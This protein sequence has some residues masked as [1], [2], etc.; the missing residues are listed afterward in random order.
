MNRLITIL[1]LAS[2]LGV[3][4]ASAQSEAGT[5]K[6]NPAKSKY[7]GIATPMRGDT[8]GTHRLAS[9]ALGSFG[10]FEYRA[11]A[12]LFRL[13][14]QFEFRVHGLNRVKS[15]QSTRQEQCHH[16]EKAA[17]ILTLTRIRESGRR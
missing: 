17:D 1:S 7:S 3:S 14:G 12:P 8:T 6:L 9:S 11:A 4:I 10:P 2:L 16:L 15:D 5:W 13:G